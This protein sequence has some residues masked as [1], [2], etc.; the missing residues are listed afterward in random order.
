MER[1][2]TIHELM[3]GVPADKAQASARP[4]PKRTSR[5]SRRTPSPSGPDAEANLP[6][7]AD[8][9]LRTLNAEVGGLSKAE[10]SVMEKVVLYAGDS[11]SEHHEWALKLYVKDISARLR[12]GS[13]EGDGLVV[14]INVTKAEPKPAATEER[15]A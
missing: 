6:T 13:G 12:K 1:A 5:R 7:D 2:Q 14:I 10:R 3:Y 8:E 11:T 4:T 9:I 15:S